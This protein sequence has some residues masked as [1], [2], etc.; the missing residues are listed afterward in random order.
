MPAAAGA[1]RGHPRTWS[2]HFALDLRPAGTRKAIDTVPVGRR[3]PA[4]RNYDW[5][6]NV[7]ELEHLVER[8]VI[9]ADDVVLP[10]PLPP[11]PEPLR[12][13]VPTPPTLRESERALIMNALESTGWVVGGAQGAAARLG[14]HRTTLINR[15][16][17]L[18]I[19]RPPSDPRGNA[20]ADA[21]SIARVDD[22]RTCA[23]NLNNF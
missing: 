10:N 12:R 8:A 22:A 1:A 14:L 11:A 13:T 21:R 2:R 6:G 7:R 4:L 15:M 20:W 17:R 3:T 9:M 18:G 16:K 23:K 19:T 5:P